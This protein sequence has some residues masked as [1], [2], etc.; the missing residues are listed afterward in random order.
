MG[1]SFAV[2]LADQSNEPIVFDL[3]PD[4]EFS[5]ARP[6]PGFP[7]AEL[8]AHASEGGVQ[9]IGAFLEFFEA[10]MEPDEFKRFKEEARTRRVDLET[11]M[12]IGGYVIEQGAGRPTPRRSDSLES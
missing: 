4:A 8:A 11:L 10:V 3:G 9:A 1:R 5:I 7:V 2:A 6:L 12:E